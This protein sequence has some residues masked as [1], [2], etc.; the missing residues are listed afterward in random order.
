M[1]TLMTTADFPEPVRFDFWRETVCK[2]FLQVECLQMSDRTF[3]G[4][5]NT[6]RIK[7][8]IFSQVQGREHKIIRN[9]AMVRRAREDMVFIFHQIRGSWLYSQDSREAKLYPGD[10]ACVDSSRPMLAIQ[11]SDFEQ[12]VFQMPRDLWVKRFGQTEQ[13][14]GR[15][16][17][18]DTQIGSLLAGTIRQIT[19][20]AENVA[21]MT[22]HQL[23][24]VALS[25]FSLAF[26]DLISHQTPSPSTSRVALLYRAKMFIEDNFRDPELDS[27]KVA[28]ALRISERYLQS[29]FQDEQISV[30]RWIWEMRL[31]KCCRDLADPLHAGKSVGEIAFNCGFNNLS[32]FCHRF[33]AAFAM[34]ASEF[35]HE[36]QRQARKN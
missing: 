4:E 19:S 13:M 25:L 18:A 24:D 26:G 35:R 12:F 2:H 3:F 31:K 29:L 33:K 36:Q 20:T 22:A 21:P 15:V 16:V 6:S 34:T 27:E 11:D 5:I 28:K 14:T 17:R 1:R 32:H 10:F 9:A 23:L 7:D 8:V 30:R